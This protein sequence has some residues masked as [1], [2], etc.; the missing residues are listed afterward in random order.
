MISAYNL[1]ENVNVIPPELAT[2]EELKSFHSEEY[3]DFLRKVNDISEEEIMADEEEEMEKFGIGMYVLFL[4]IVL[5]LSAR[6][7]IKNR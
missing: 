3:I 7:Q 1:L 2:V 6:R 4:N 5:K